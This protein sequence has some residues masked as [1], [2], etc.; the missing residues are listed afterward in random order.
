MGNVEEAREFFLAPDNTLWPIVLV[1]ALEAHRQRLAS[2]WLRRCI[3]ILLP[4]VVTDARETLLV[5]LAELDNCLSAGPPGDELIRRGLD[6]WYQPQRDA[7]R[8]AV[9]HTYCAMARRDDVTPGADSARASP[10][11]DLVRNSINPG[12]VREVVLTDFREFAGENG[13]RCE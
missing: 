8:R 7:A 11:W 2:A 6:I 13:L 9:S 5:D 12:E 1:R 3:R 10:I 4:L